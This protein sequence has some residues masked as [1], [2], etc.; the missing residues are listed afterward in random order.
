MK[1]TKAQFRAIRERVGIS[2]A[3]LADALGNEISTVK[4]W[5]NPRYVEP[6]TDAWE[7]LL[8][9]LAAHED[10]VEKS[11]NVVKKMIKKNGGRKPQNVKI[12][13]YRT[14]HQYDLYGRDKGDYQ[15]VD[16]RAREVAVR[17]EQMGVGVEFHY[18]EDSERF[19]SNLAKTRS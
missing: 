7:Y 1:K 5:E 17:L 19:F 10:A 18:P 8:D 6:P 3:A 13:Y 15:I 9:A 12:L 14:Q 11:V 4:R 2:Q 16:A